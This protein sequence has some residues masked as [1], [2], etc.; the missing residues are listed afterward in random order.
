MSAASSVG[1]LLPRS[2]V[3]CGVQHTAQKGD[4]P[5]HTL[6]TSASETCTALTVHTIHGTLLNPAVPPTIERRPERQR[7]P[8]PSPGFRNR[9]SELATLREAI[10]PGK[11]AW[12]Q[13]AEGAGISTLLYQMT[14]S[15]PARLMTDGVVYVDGEA[16]PPIFDDIMQRLFDRFYTSDVP[17]KVTPHMAEAHL[18]VIQALLVLD[19]MPLNP[20][21]LVLLSD[22]LSSSALLVAADSRAPERLRHVQ[23][24]GLPLQ[25]AI[26]LCIASSRIE[27][28]STKDRL[29]LERLCNE[30]DSLPLPLL[31]LLRPVMGDSNRLEKLT[32]ALER[33]ALDLPPLE[34]AVTVVLPELRETELAV[35]MALVGAGGSD[36]SL[37]MLAAISQ[38][39]GDHLE[40]ALAQLSELGLVRQNA[41]RVGIRSRGLRNTLVRMLKPAQAQARAAAV[42]AGALST[43]QSEPGWIGAEL[44]NLLAAVQT[45]LDTG[46]MRQLGIL[47]RGLQPFL[48][49]RGLWGLWEQVIDWAEQAA[50]RTSDRALYAWSLHER[51]TYAG[52]QGDYR[53]ASRAL[54]E[55]QRL[56]RVLGDETG[57]ATSQ[58]NLTYLSLLPAATPSLAPEERASAQRGWSQPSAAHWIIGALPLII[59]LFSIGIHL[60]FPDMFAF[61]FMMPQI[62]TRT[63]TVSPSPSPSPTSVVVSRP[64]LP[65]GGTYP[66][67]PLTSPTATTLPVSPSPTAT[68]P[69]PS[70]DVPEE[71]PPTLEPAPDNPPPLPNV[72]DD[73]PVPTASPI[74]IPT[75]PLPTSTYT[76]RPATALPVAT[77][78]PRPA[79]ATPQPDAPTST[80]DTNV[81]PSVT[82][83]P[84]NTTELAEAELLEP[85]EDAELACGEDVLLRWSEVEPVSGSAGTVMY[86]WT[87]E[88][89][90]REDGTTEFLTFEDG[91]TSDVSVELNDVP[92]NTEY[93]WQVAAAESDSTAQSVSEDRFFSVAPTSTTT[94]TPTPTP[95]TTAPDAPDIIAPSN[96]RVFDCAEAVTLVWNAATDPSGI[97]RYQWQVDE[98]GNDRN[99][100]YSFFRSGDATGRSV[101]LLELPCGNETIWYRWRV[102]AIDTVGNTGEFSE[103]R[104][105]QVLN[106]P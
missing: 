96:S 64:T 30:L 53:F 61:S 74:V 3:F 13:S 65:G 45:S 68:Q 66:Y 33:T 105:F 15:P 23:L 92:C 6:A 27:H 47:A 56:R 48:V 42:F 93:R 83:T 25:E 97:D 69:T 39:S 86:T 8:R 14:D 90:L 67:P 82:A 55:A 19:Q 4:L 22:M 16:E 80:P 20:A 5:D 79:T 77:P 32:N 63:P 76:A 52:V 95:D 31:L 59:L 35:L 78:T 9:Q 57:A 43:R 73:T 38:L 89:V 51:G 60:L 44:G 29:L 94:P 72:P 49:L 18:N 88:E 10:A 99:D 50:R 81:T 84:A 101:T 102:R 36:T 70:P 7:L 24:Y 37:E 54:S 106:I 58:H 100:R 21:E 34:R 2:I 40:V 41:Q 12:L 85:D 26:E 11:G 28:P 104:Y 75:E 46:D 1:L 71:L 17:I 91:T 98:G 62:P 87:V 103:Y